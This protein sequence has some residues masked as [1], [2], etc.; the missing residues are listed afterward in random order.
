MGRC[1]R[2]MDSD[3]IYKIEALITVV[4]P[5]SISSYMGS[6]LEEMAAHELH[7]PL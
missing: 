3:N 4:V 6:K 2:Q 1:S 7:S 5:I